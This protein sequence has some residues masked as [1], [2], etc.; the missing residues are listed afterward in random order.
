M[1]SVHISFIRFVRA[2]SNVSDF[3]CRNKGHNTGY[4]YHKLRKTFS[5]FYRRH[6]GLVEK[7][8]VSSR[9][10]LQQGISEPEFYRNLVYRIRKIVGKSNFAEQF[11][12]LS[13]CY[14]KIGYA[15][16]LHA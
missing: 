8:N 15:D 16:R 5:K 4:R 14:N 3:N 9:K 12:K 13:N 7:Y 6:S 1:W 11:R 2:S 10:L